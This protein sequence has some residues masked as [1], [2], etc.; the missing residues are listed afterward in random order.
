MKLRFWSFAALVFLA[1][2]AALVLGSRSLSYR[3]DRRFEAR[4]VVAAHALQSRL[5]AE[6]VE[7]ERLARAAAAVDVV[8]KEATS[9]AK[10]SGEGLK[11]AADS[12]PGKPTL[13]AFANASGIAVSR[14][15][16]PDASLDAL[17]ALPFAADAVKGAG[18]HG[19]AVYD[20]AFYV[21][22]A[23]PIAAPPAPPPTMPPEGDLPTLAAPPA[24]AGQAGAV[25][26]GRTLSDASALELKEQTGADVTFLAGGKVAASTLPLADR[27][28]AEAW[29]ALPTRRGFGAVRLHFPL[30][31]FAPI[32]EKF[33]RLSN[34][35]VHRPARL[36]LPGGGIVVLSEDASL[37]LEH[38][39]RAQLA[40][41]A[42][43]IVFGL[44]SLLAGFVLDRGLRRQ[45][46]IVAHGAARLL[47]DRAQRIPTAA[48]SGPFKA[49]ALSLNQSAEVA[50]HR[51]AQRV[52]A[53]VE[54]RT[55]SGASVAPIS[56]DVPA[57]AAPEA[58]APL[59]AE[60]ALLGGSA[61]LG[62]PEPGTTPADAFEHVA[63]VA[64]QTEA[65]AEAEVAAPP[66]WDEAPTDAVAAPP[67]VPA[68][69]AEPAAA[70]EATSPW[71]AQPGDA[72]APLDWSALP[73]P[74]DEPAP[75]EEHE[76]HTLTDA[77]PLTAASGE[78]A[79]A[80]EP[81]PVAEPYGALGDE[82][83]QT[84]AYGMPV[85]PAAA[86]EEPVTA[87]PDDAA[88]LED[89]GA[90]LAYGAPAIPGEGGADPFASFGA[91][92][93]AEHEHATAT[94]VRA[95]TPELL[96]ASRREEEP[97]LEAAP[98]P[99]AYAETVVEAEPFAEPGDPDQAHWHEVHERFVS[100]RDSLG[101]TGAMPYEKF[102]E[103]L[104]KNRETLVAKH[105]C[106]S[107]RFTVFEKEGKA[108]I[109]ATPVK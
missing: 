35:A 99:A 93:E 44:F 72:P 42:A 74:A 17:I 40:G 61:L 37:E 33:P 23:A 30:S 71:D 52:I 21:F 62:E 31:A 92:P 69:T 79:P 73:A 47:D 41:L 22:G 13:A 27:P 63:E 32:A 87:P 101:E 96:A 82:P 18:A 57:A 12:A 76:S 8:Q 86:E 4:L 66:S 10:P 24:P 106:K 48:L 6:G 7:V 84:L 36:E 81:A 59:P 75:A 3:A 104:R 14:L 105:L 2:A 107:V 97:A 70:E 64:A 85:V 11:A 100:L 78:P 20:G 56:L 90:T 19:V 89:A 103:R 53:K 54:G 83:A 9:P 45:L 29:A 28:A 95:P 1:M 50:A 102:A 26:L 34:R 88:P 80:E 68:W 49:A 91:P 5:G 108:A 98:E 39:A 65:G 25:I 46:D 109:K 15:G 43:L 16:K 38:L 67:E 77:R 58:A 60:P 94:A 51:E 55:P